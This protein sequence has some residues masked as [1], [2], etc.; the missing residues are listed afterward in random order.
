MS[1]LW[2][3]LYVGTGLQALVHSPTDT[4][5]LC[6]TRLVRLLAYG[7]TS[8]ILVLYL[9]CLGISEERIGIFMTLTLLGDVVISLGLTVVADAVGRRRM[10]A[11]G[12]LLMAGSGVIFAT[13]RE[14]WVLVAASVLGVVSPRYGVPLEA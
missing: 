2:H 3:K 4:K 8:L 5:I 10:L 13:R 12:S 11:F 9:T 1:S 7:G 14:Y 6:L